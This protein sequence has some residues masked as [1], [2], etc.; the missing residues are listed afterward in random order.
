VWVTSDHELAVK[1]YRRSNSWGSAPVRAVALVDQAFI[2]FNLHKGLDVRYFHCPLPSGDL[3]YVGIETKLGLAA[4]LH[5][6][7]ISAT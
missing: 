2:G 1:L 6:Y 7:R 4:D 5:A 3:L